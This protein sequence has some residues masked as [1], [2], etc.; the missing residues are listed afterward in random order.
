MTCV[1][2]VAL[3]ATDARAQQSPDVD[4]RTQSQ[5]PV[6]AVLVIPV[7]DT[8]DVG[9]GSAGHVSQSLRIQPII[10]VHLTQDWLLVSRVLV[11]AALVRTDVSPAAVQTTSVGDITGTFFFSPTRVGHVVWGIGPTVLMPTATRAAFGRGQWAIGPAA[12]VFTR[13]KSGAIGVVAHNKWS[14]AGDSSRTT[15][16]QL[17]LELSASWNLAHGW[18]LTTHPELDADWSTHVGHR[19]TVPMGGGIG[20]AFEVGPQSFSGAVT[21][22]RNAMSATSARWQINLQL[23]LLFP[24]KQAG[25]K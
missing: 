22:Y 18:Y 13:L 25:Q 12:G 8:I 2:A 7:Q 19:W 15:V 14:I 9:P 11:N 1:L 24:H 3:C 23:A 6:A 16:N 10:P 17:A 21:V 5:N 4:V 20:R